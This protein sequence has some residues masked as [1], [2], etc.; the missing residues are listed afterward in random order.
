MSKRMDR[1]LLH[2]ASAKRTANATLGVLNALQNW[3][4]EE[5]LLA[6]AIVFLN[7]A[8]FWQVSAQDAFTAATNMLND[9]DGKV[10]PE[11]GAVRPYMEG[12][13]R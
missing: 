10:R 7:L 1:D 3:T 12:E 9:K 13:L 5:Q 6:S 11:F 2:M 4:R 8:D